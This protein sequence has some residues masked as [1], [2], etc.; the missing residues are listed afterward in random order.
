MTVPFSGENGNSE[1]CNTFDFILGL[2]L[3][4]ALTADSHEFLSVLQTYQDFFGSFNKFNEALTPVR[5]YYVA[6]VCIVCM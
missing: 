4:G 1:Y 3:M 5:T 2:V 6:R